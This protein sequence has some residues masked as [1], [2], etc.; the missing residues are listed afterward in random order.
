MILEMYLDVLNCVQ[1]LSFHF[2]FFVLFLHIQRFK[3][4]SGFFL[5]ILVY[6]SALFPCTWFLPGTKVKRQCD[7]AHLCQADT[8]KLACVGPAVIAIAC[9]REQSI[10]VKFS[11]SSRCLSF[12][13]FRETF[14]Y[15]FSLFNFFLFL[16]QIK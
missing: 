6:I 14:F 5:L 7:D 3:D 1:F 12:L 16:L 13:S 11:T 9:G 8:S 2:L 15:F 10:N 4:L